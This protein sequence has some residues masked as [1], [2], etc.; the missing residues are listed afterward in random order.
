MNNNR[1]DEF[2]W[3]FGTVFPF[4]NDSTKKERFEMLTGGVKLETAI[5]EV[6]KIIS[7]LIQDNKE[8]AEMWFRFFRQ[9]IDY[10]MENSND[11]PETTIPQDEINRL[12]RIQ[13]K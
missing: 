13:L 6:L 10:M 11:L 3:L 5:P 9:G 1:I 7:R 12:M 4:P 8:D 2:F